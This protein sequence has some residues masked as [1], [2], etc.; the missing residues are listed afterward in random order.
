M[1]LYCSEKHTEEVAA[2]VWAYKNLNSTET[3]FGI[4]SPTSSHL[5]VFPF[6]QEL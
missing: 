6:N 5:Q 3:S 1:L 2:G 4:V